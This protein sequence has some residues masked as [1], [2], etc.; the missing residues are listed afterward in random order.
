MIK[1]GCG[2]FPAR[3]AA[4]IWLSLMFKY[5]ATS[6]NRKIFRGGV[7]GFLVLTV[8]NGRPALRFVIIVGS[9][10]INCNLTENA[11]K[12]LERKEFSLKLYNLLHLQH[13]A[14]M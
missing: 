8:P 4:L 1:K 3:T 6:G 2:K 10:S 12:F 7:R 5:A 14:S 11:L 13:D 9:L